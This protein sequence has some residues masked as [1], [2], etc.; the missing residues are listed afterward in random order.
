MAV[1]WFWLWSW[2]FR[3]YY[4]MV[5]VMA[6][7]RGNDDNEAATDY[8][9]DHDDACDGD[10]G[11]DGDVEHSCI[12]SPDDMWLSAELL[13]WCAGN[14]HAASARGP[15]DREAGDRGPRMEPAV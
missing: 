11:G 15:K 8:D 7:R 9:H 4:C 1:L 3:L 14:H 6:T 5:I 13:L 10:D 12:T 2:Q